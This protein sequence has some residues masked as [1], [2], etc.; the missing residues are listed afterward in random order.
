MLRHLLHVEAPLKSNITFYWFLTVIKTGPDT[1]QTYPMFLDGHISEVDK[2]VVQFTR[3]GR[4]LHC[5]EPT[6]AQLVPERVKST[7]SMSF[8]DKTHKNLEIKLVM[9]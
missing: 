1:F 3:T 7:T 2:H 9:F 8:Y 4:V 6:E 5:A